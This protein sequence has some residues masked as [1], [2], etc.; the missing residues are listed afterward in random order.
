MWHELIHMY[1]AGYIVAGFI[2][3]GV[4]ALAWLRGRRDRYHRTALVVTLASRAW[5]RRCR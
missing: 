3:A 5:P 4:Y 2:V 1:L